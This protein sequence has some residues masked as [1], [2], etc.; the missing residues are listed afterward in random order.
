MRRCCKMLEATTPCGEANYLIVY[1]SYLL[2]QSRV[3][4]LTAQSINRPPG[5]QRPASITDRV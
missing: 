3:K 4:T 5:Q 2:K 1:L